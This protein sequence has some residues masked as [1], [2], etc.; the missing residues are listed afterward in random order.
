MKY[1]KYYLPLMSLLLAGICSAIFWLPAG[2]IPLPPTCHAKPVGPGRRGTGGTAIALDFL[3]VACSF[4]VRARPTR[5]P[6]PVRPLRRPHR[7]AV[8]DACRPSGGGTS[9]DGASGGRAAAD[10]D[11]EPAAQPGAGIRFPHIAPRRPGRPGR[12]PPPW[13]I[14]LP[15]C[16]ASPHR[17][18]PAHPAPAG[19]RA[20]GRAESAGPYAGCRDPAASQATTRKPPAPP[21]SAKTKSTKTYV[22]RR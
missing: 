13:P 22:W 16:P 14:P 21:A 12:R 9:R 4:F 11:L 18:T 7:G 20:A 3:G 19:R 10:A 8:P 2:V 17:G 15:A 6:H 1:L 5:R